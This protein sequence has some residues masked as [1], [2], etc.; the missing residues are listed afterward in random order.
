MKTEVTAKATRENTS[1]FRLGFCGSMY[2]LKA[3][4]A[5]QHALDAIKWQINSRQVEVWTVGAAISFKSSTPADCRFFGWRSVDETAELLS[6]C[7]LLYL[8]QPFDGL[9]EPLARLSFPTKL[10][11][12]AATGRPVFIHTPDWG[13]LNDF[14]KSNKMKL[15]CNS[16]NPVDVVSTLRQIDSEPSL[17]DNEAINTA[18]ISNTILSH[19]EFSKQTRAF[20]TPS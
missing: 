14:A 1:T 4:R 17:L 7:D 11:T 20:L 6:Q 16:T 13:S 9:N 15:V 3:W 18:R 10:S 5:L 2:C 8:P 12:Y 19:S